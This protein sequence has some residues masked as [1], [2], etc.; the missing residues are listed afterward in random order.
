MKRFLLYF[1]FLLKKYWFVGLGYGEDLCIKWVFYKIR[2]LIM[3]D[4]KK[5]KIDYEFRKW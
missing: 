3:N 5:K 1:Y 4:V 2:K